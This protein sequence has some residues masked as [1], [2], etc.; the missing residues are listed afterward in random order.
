MLA[1]E[2]ELTKKKNCVNGFAIRLPGMSMESSLRID[3][4]PK[5]PA[6]PLT[7]LLTYNT[8]LSDAT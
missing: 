4:R 7:T 8:F 3:L 2:Y 1:T 5:D 6:H